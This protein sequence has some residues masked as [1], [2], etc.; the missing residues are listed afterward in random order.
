MLSKAAAGI[1]ATNSS[2][3]YFMGEIHVQ[4][5]RDNFMLKPHGKTWKFKW[6][7][8]NNSGKATFLS[9]EEPGIKF[10]GSLTKTGR[11]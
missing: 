1:H 2:L 7:K 6:A 3:Y 10:N 8:R 11:S 5:S 4:T 9:H